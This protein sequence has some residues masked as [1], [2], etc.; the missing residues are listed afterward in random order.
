MQSVMIDIE[1]LGLGP[2]APIVQIAA[3]TFDILDPEFNQYCQPGTGT[4]DAGTMTF[5]LEMEDEARLTLAKGLRTA[6]PMH[7][8]L[9][10]LRDWFGSLGTVD[11][12][13]SHGPAFDIHLL[14]NAFAR[15]H[16]EVPWHYRSIRD[17]RTLYQLAYGE[18]TPPPIDDHH[19]AHNALDDCRA[20]VIQVQDAI[21]ELCR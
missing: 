7:D 16:M 1:T 17:T 21:K 6:M 8:V 2:N 10:D 3:T 12:V 18:P 5:W 11:E 13:W 20:Q 19:V 15:H 4:V 14:S 9:W